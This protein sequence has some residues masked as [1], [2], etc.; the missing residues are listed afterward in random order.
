MADLRISIAKTLIHEGGFVNNP[1][2]PGGATNM[3]ITQNDIPGT[4]VKSLTPDQATNWYLT[5]LKPQR[6]N[7]PLY[8]EIQSQDVC[9]KIFDMGILF[10]VGTAVAILQA[11]LKITADAHFG[12]DTLAAINEADDV[13]LLNSYKTNLVTHAFNVATAHPAERIFLKGWADRINS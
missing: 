13:S 1:A 7:N 8:A 11:T 3:G 12:P 9:N 2:D 10:G 4:D 5:T 6:F